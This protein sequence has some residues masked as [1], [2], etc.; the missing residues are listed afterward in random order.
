MA[1]SDSWRVHFLSGRVRCRHRRVHP[2]RRP[3]KARA[4]VALRE[5]RDGDLPARLRFRFHDSDDGRSLL[6]R[7]DDRTCR[8]S[9]RRCL[10][11]RD[12][13]DVSALLQ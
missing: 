4:T 11:E 2:V 12:F 6:F 3:V 10:E 5:R 13:L 9:P 8:R 7:Q 1:S